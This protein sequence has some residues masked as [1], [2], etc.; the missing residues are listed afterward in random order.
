MWNTVFCGTRQPMATGTDL[1]NS[2]MSPNVIMPAGFA[3]L[4]TNKR[5]EG[6]QGGS[7]FVNHDYIK[8]TG[9]GNSNSPAQLHIFPHNIN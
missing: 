3:T 6:K 8:P 9:H 1:K 2:P 4:T 7:V 5:E